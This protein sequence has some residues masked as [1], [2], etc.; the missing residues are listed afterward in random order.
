MSSIK[1]KINKVLADYASIYAELLR[2]IVKSTKSLSDI[3]S[4]SQL[5][6]LD[7]Q[8]NTQKNTVSSLVAVMIEKDKELHLL[9]KELV[10]HQEFQSKIRS[11][12]RLVEE[13]NSQLSNLSTTLEHIHSDLLT[14]L[15]DTSQTTKAMNTRKE[16]DLTDVTSYAHRIS[17]TTSAP[18][19]DQ[20][21]LKSPPYPPPHVWSASL[22]YPKNRK[23]YEEKMK[24]SLTEEKKEPEP[25]SP[26]K[27][28][29]STATI[30]QVAYH[31]APQRQA[32]QIAAP[33]EL[34]GLNDASSD[35][36]SDS[37]SDSE[38]D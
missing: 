38:S 11:V 2:E 21:A 5:E 8:I 37:D 27:F 7:L 32:Q 29:A 20:A 31:A 24:Q 33:I 12:R 15:H 10:V 26:A 16:V 35:S 28:V 13:K 34:F 17:G 3:G 36:E 30:P 6:I 22:L 14:S 18:S 23:A 9:L 19:M 25:P 1:Q 4:G